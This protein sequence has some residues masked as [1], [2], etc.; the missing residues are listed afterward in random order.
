MWGDGLRASDW[1]QIH[2]CLLTGSVCWPSAELHKAAGSCK[3]QWGSLSLL[4]PENNAVTWQFYSCAN[5]TNFL[6]YVLKT[7]L[8]KITHHCSVN[9]SKSLEAK[10]RGK[11][12]SDDLM[13]CCSD[14]SLIPVTPQLY[15]DWTPGQPTVQLT[16]GS[17]P[18]LESSAVHTNIKTS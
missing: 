6:D 9:D 1:G 11:L 17:Q 15:R 18:Q 12:N 10:R 14:W 16:A 2:V 3:P 5:E 13:L 4:L 8:H 7:A